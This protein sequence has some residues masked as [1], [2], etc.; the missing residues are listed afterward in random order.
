MRLI[1]LRHVAGMMSTG[2][3]PRNPSRRRGSDLVSDQRAEGDE[4][5]IATRAVTMRDIA[6]AAGVSQ[7]TVSR[8]LNGTAS[9]VPIAPTTR[10]RIL[11]VVERLGYR[12]NPLARGLRGAPTMLLG[13]IVREITDPFFAGAVE[14]IS[15][16]AGARGY[17]VV[18]GHA[19][20]RADEAIAL[21]AVLETRHCDA[22]LVLG[23]TSE[24]PRLVADLREAHVPVV[25]MWQGAGHP[26]ITTVSVDNHHGIFAVL[27]YLTGLGHRD[28]AF[29]GSRS[30]GDTEQRRSAYH[31]YM[32]ARGI[33]VLPAFDHQASNDPGAAAEAL[34]QLVRDRRRPTAVLTSTDQQAIGALHAAHVLGVRVPE[35]LSVVGFDNIAMAAFTVPALTTVQMPIKAMAAAAVLAVLGGEEATGPGRPHDVLL[36]PSL[37]VRESSGPVLALG[38][39]PG[40]STMR[41]D[42]R[43]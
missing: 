9:P 6:T 38:S 31:E 1:D 13:V 4:L 37:V 10:D 19:H 26:Q 18:L 14:A 20:G 30:L 33:H 21:R 5:G 3:D 27:D 39:H 35:E 36:R 2:R 7:S 12:P 28:I 32:A 16:E 24:Q 29:I 23:D 22:I 40:T 8:V 34:K 42:R 43:D 41:S 17:N 11:T 25:A 15:D